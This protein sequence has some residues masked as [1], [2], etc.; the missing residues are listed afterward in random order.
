MV[1]I[2]SE[3]Y[4]LQVIVHIPCMLMVGKHFYQVLCIYNPG[5]FITIVVTTG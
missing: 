2:E 4:F 1:I 5:V 3:A